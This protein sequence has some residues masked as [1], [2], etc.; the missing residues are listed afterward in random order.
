MT[1]QEFLRLIAGGS[2]GSFGASADIHVDAAQTPAKSFPVGV[3]KA[4]VDFVTRT[5][6]TDVP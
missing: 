4:I 5:S 3:T 1:R 6:L 2:I